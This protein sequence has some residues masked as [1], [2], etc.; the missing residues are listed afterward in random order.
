MRTKHFLLFSFVFITILSSCKKELLVTNETVLPQN[1]YTLMRVAYYR[2]LIETDGIGV[3]F[4]ET[5]VVI[6]LYK[7]N[8]NF[9][10]IKN[11][12]DQSKEQNNPLRVTIKNANELDVANTASTS[13]LSTY[14]LQFKKV[15]PEPE[16]IKRI[17]P[18]MDVFLD[19]FN[20]MQMQGCDT[21]TVTIDQCISFQYVVD[22]CYARAHK[23]R[24]ILIDNYK[25]SC[26]KVFS[27]EGEDGYLAVDAGDCCVYWWYHVA[28]LVSVNEDGIINKYVM[29]P[30][31]FDGP[32]TIDEWTGAQENEECTPYADFGEYDIQR[33]Q[34]YSPWGEW[35]GV[36]YYSTDEDYSSTNSTLYWYSDLETCY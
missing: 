21:G 19:I 5:P 16:K 3:R 30:S 1:E 10:A 28:P 29:D 2:D 26:E 18:S 34:F 7:D 8:V 20:F 32:V 36:M 17:L 12:I 14:N 33:G 24:Q 11:I 22:G 35:G 23:M 27:Y 15:L 13:E 25:Y 4:Y 9:A 31:M 6:N